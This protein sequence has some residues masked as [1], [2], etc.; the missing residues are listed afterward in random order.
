MCQRVGYVSPFED[1]APHHW[2][3]ALVIDGEQMQHLEL[4]SQILNV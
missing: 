3:L 4:E 1:P 2:K